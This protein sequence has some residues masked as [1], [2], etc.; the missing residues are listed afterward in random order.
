[1]CVEEVY[2]VL[3]QKHKGSKQKTQFTLQTFDTLKKLVL[4]SK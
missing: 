3:Q 1:M 4:L 2:A